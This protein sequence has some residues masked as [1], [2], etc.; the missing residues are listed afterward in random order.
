MKIDCGISYT[1]NAAIENEA[2]SQFIQVTQKMYTTK[3]MWNVPFV[4]KCPFVDEN[5]AFH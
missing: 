5:V 2:S 4:G 1:E 3:V